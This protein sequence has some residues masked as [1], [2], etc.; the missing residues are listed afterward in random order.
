MVPPFSSTAD[1]A[2]KPS[3]LGANGCGTLITT[4]QRGMPRPHGAGCDIGAFEF[5][6]LLHL[7]LILSS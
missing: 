4:D 7:P 5:N 2:D 3:L 1:S 6:F